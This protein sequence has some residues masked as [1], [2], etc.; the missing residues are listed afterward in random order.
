[1]TSSPSRLLALLLGAAL[2]TACTSGEAEEVPLPSADPCLIDSSTQELPPECVQDGND[3]AGSSPPAASAAIEPVTVAPTDNELGRAANDKDASLT[4]TE[5]EVTV[6]AGGRLKST[7][8]CNGT[9]TA[10]LVTVPKAGAMQ[11]FRCE[12]GDEPVELTVEAAT[13]VSEATTYRV[14]FTS[15]A[16]ARWALVLSYVMGAPEAEELPGG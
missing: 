14:T 11:E 4:T 3:R 8:A 13:P 5:L 15:G 9:G 12:Y 10:K 2:L 1:M 6:P 7:V 16:P